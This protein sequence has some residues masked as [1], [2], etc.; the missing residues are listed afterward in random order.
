[1]NLFHEICSHSRGLN[2]ETVRDRAEQLGGSE[3]RVDQ[4][5]HRTR[6]ADAIDERARQRGLARSDLADEHRQLFLVDGIFE[7]RQGFG[8][9]RA[10]VE[11]TR[12]GSF[13]ER[14][15]G[16]AEEVLKHWPISTP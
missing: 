16:E 9:L 15:G 10:L 8:V 1:M 6:V 7:S 12:I 2:A 5:D 14:L 3:A 4:P 13:P 11:K